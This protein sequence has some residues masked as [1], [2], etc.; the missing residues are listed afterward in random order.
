MRL[1]NRVALI[2]LGVI[3]LGLLFLQT[4][5]MRTIRGQAWET[6]TARFFRIG[7]LAVSSDTQHQLEQLQAENISLKSQLAEYERLKAQLGSPTVNTL[8]I[9]PAA[10]IGQPVGLFQERYVVTKGIR[11]GVAIGSPVLLSG[12]TL[13]GFVVDVTPETAT[14]E[15]LFVPSTNLTVSI[16]PE[17]P[18]IPVTKGLLT[19]VHYTSLLLS[20]IP[21]SVPLKDGLSVVTAAGEKLPAGLFIGSLSHITNKENEPYQTAQV[22]TTYNPH[23][24]EAVTILALP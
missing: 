3:I 7:T 17:D 14:V 1:G 23:E 15:L 22:T 21:R 9:I 24:I 8:R 19:G 2:I 20:T 12:T 5:L 16:V 11:D 10:V 13:I 6:L 18:D 4:P